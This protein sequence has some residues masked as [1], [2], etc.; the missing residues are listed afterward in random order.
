MNILIFLL[1]YHNDM[2]F[3]AITS[4]SRSIGDLE[5]R[6][7]K[8]YHFKGVVAYGVFRGNHFPPLK[9]PCYYSTPATGGALFSQIEDYAT[10]LAHR[11]KVK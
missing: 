6:V 8:W 3:A 2:F 10:G 4:R 7:C 5:M 1:L 9:L 11:L